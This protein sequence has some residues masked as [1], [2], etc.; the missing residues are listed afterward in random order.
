MINSGVYVRQYLSS[1]VMSQPSVFSTNNRVIPGDTA[2]YMRY[3]SQT[4]VIEY[5]TGSSWMT[6]PTSSTTLS[7]DHEVKLV[8]EWAKTKIA[9]EAELQARLDKYPSLKEAYEQFKM[10]E[11]LTYNETTNNGN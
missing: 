3:N 6:V 10:L 2:G 9:E 1:E 8:I 11:A 5:C 4:N 7:L